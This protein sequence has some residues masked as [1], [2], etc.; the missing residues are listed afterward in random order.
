MSFNKTPQFNEL[1]SIIYQNL[2]LMKNNEKLYKVLLRI[3]CK[4][5]DI[6]QVKSN[7]LESLYFINR[8]EED[9][10]MELALSL[11]D[12]TQE[13]Y[14]NWETECVEEDVNFDKFLSQLEGV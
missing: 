13:E 9:I 7:E 10:Q 8:R 3:H 2:R 11:G 14:N 1:E 4:D 12:I 5:L 6:S